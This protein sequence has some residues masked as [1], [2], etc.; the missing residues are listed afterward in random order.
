MFKCIKNIVIKKIKQKN[1]GE[2]FLNIITH[3]IFI[4]KF[5]KILFQT[6]LKSIFCVLYVKAYFC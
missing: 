4:Y 2:L 3:L 1:R 6:P 5:E